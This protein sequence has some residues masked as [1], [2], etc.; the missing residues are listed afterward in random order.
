MEVDDEDLEDHSLMELAGYMLEERFKLTG[1]RSRA[2]KEK[3]YCDSH[4]A[5][6]YRIEFVTRYL[7]T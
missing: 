3:Q 2:T 4:L 5:P 7:H 1:H 6:F